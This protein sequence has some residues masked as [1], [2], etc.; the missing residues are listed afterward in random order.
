MEEEMWRLSADR[1]SPEASVMAKGLGEESEIGE[2]I[3]NPNRSWADM[4][5]EAD[6]QDVGETEGQLQTSEGSTCADQPPPAPAPTD[7]PKRLSNYAKGVEQ[8]RGDSWEWWYFEKQHK[9]EWPAKKRGTR[10][11]W[12]HDDNWYQWQAKTPEHDDADLALLVG[13][14]WDTR[15][16]RGSC[17]TL[18]LD[19][20]HASL[21][22]HEAKYDGVQKVRPAQ[23]K[24][25]Y[26][27]YAKTMRIFWG[28]TFVLADGLGGRSPNKIRWESLVPHLKDFVWTRDDNQWYETQSKTVYWRAKSENND[29]DM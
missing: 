13:K 1:I 12:P 4:S 27:S 2:H 26:C 21:S 11:E 18:S 25:G 15:G 24:F 9:Q 5:E 17:Y 19:T 14:W 6:L 23:I 22:V 10:V 3:D 7:W 28:H 29:D 20:D 8:R 16:S